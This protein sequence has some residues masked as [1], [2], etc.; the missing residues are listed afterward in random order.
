[1]EEAGVCMRGR[2][3]SCA[4]VVCWMLWVPF[5]LRLTMCGF[6][7]FEG[8]GVYLE[9]ANSVSHGNQTVRLE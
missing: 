9:F 8:K 7:F 1:M 6:F 2:W 4:S 3:A 5:L